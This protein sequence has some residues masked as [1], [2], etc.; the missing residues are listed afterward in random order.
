VWLLGTKEQESS[1]KKEIYERL[2][3]LLIE[4]H[5]QRWTNIAYQHLFIRK[6][7]IDGN[8]CWGVLK[9]NS[10]IERVK[11]YLPLN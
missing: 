2:V 1:I 5:I 3:I 10:S 9:F 6:K 4:H 8:N 11:L 7:K